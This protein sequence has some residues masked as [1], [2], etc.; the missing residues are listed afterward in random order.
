[1]SCPSKRLSGSAQFKPIG[2]FRSPRSRYSGTVRPPCLTPTGAKQRPFANQST[3]PA[4]DSLEVQT[5]PG[6]LRASRM[7]APAPVTTISSR[8]NDRQEPINR[9]RAGPAVF[10]TGST[11]LAGWPNRK[12][13]AQKVDLPP[14]GG[15]P[16][17]V[18]GRVPTCHA[19]QQHRP[20]RNASTGWAPPHWSQQ[21]K[22]AVQK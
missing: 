4:R 6:R 16:S 2:L 14:K 19:R 17:P 3:V 18:C 15:H 13:R 21:S 10:L 22:G 11:H 5:G 9:T 12:H 7:G 8:P 1:M 20:G